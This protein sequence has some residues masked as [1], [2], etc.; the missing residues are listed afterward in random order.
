MKR[1]TLISAVALIAVIGSSAASFAQGEKDMDRRGG[2]MPSIE[3]FDTNGDGQVTQE[4]M[5][6]HKAARFAETDTDGNGSLSAEE[7]AAAAKGKKAER[8]TKRI[9]K[10]ISRMDTDGDGE[11]SAAEMDAMAKKS[12]FER[13]DTNGDGV[14]S[15]EEFAAGHHGH[16]KG[17]GGKHHKGGDHDHDSD[18]N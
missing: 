16:S 14:L 4:E 11:V 8:Q 12:P 9:E 5:D 6:A 10:M 7:M 15:A 2:K 13:L 17:K 1:T 18:D 3:M